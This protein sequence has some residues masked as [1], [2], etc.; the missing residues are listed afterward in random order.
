ML[1]LLPLLGILFI[2]PLKYTN[3]SD[4]TPIE[5]GQKYIKIALIFTLAN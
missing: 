3:S 1:L 5:M 4:M 2:W